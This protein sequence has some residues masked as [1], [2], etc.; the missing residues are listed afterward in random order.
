MERPY[1]AWGYPV[2][3]ILAVVIFFALM[4][5]TLMSD[6]KTAA[7]GLIVPVLGVITWFIF[8][9]K[10]ARDEKHS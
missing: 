7:I 10:I 4:I 9:K 6:P 1:K 8:D 3:V 5:N 2:T